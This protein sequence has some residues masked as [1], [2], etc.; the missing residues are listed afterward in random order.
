MQIVPYSCLTRSRTR[1]SFSSCH[2]PP[3]LESCSVSTCHNVTIE[4]KAR[5]PIEAKT[6]RNDCG[7]ITY[8]EN[9]GETQPGDRR[10]RH[11]HRRFEPQEGS[12]QTWRIRTTGSLVTN[13]E[14]SNYRKGRHKHLGYQPQEDLSQT[15]RIRTSGLLVRNTE[16]SNNSRARHKL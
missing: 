8:C 9:G 16:D 5:K 10:A 13:T 3:P 14:D 4:C 1:I 11:K 6:V 2:P 7:Y 15:T 12:S